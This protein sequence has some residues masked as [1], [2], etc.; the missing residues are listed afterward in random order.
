MR[1]GLAPHLV[2]ARLI[3][4]RQNR[5]D[6]RF[7][8]PPDF[9]GRLLG[10]RVTGLRRRAK[11]LLADLDSG[12][13]WLT[14]LGMTG[15]FLVQGL[16]PGRFAR[17][18]DPLAHVHLEIE[19]DRGA[20]VRFADPR[21]FGFMELLAGAAAAP[22][23]DALGPEPLGPDF[24]AARLLSAFAGS[25]RPVKAALLDQGVVAGLGN[26]YVCEALHQ[27]RISPMT[28]C[29]V[30]GRARLERLALAVRAVLEAAIAAGGS[31]LRDFAGAEGGQGYFQHAFQVYGREGEPCA[32]PPCRGVVARIVQSGRSTFYCP[33][34]QNR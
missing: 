2:G 17:P 7:P 23:L 30:L 21:R 10:R 32:R 26:I 4:V 6:L 24:G 19:T 14:H 9:A 16:A 3:A 12:E 29:G 27:A 22:R 18:V 20:V 1:L 8:F 34:C 5:P 33:V 15:R 31:T 28:P 13:T 11:Y 25:R